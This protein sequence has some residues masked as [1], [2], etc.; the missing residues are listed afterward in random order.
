[1]YTR[2]RLIKLE[3]GVGRGKKL[4]DKREAIKKREQDVEIARALK[5]D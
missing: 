1:L 5:E 3:L 4:H 2:G